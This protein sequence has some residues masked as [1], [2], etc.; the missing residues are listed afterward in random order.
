MPNRAASRWLAS[1]SSLASSTLPARAAAAFSSAG[2]SVRQGPHHSAQKSTTTGSSRERS[3]TR[4]SKSASVT[5]KML[6]LAVSGT[7]LRLPG[8]LYD[9]HAT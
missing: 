4:C 9:S 8:P 7:P 6:L 3:T 1:V 2:V 5:S